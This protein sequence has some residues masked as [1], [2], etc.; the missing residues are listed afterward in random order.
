LINI[1]AGA[2]VVETVEG[3]MVRVLI[4]C[5]ALLLT[6]I[7]IHAEANL[8][9]PPV[10][11]ATQDASFLKYR[12]ALLNAVIA[13]DTEAVVGFSSPKISLSFGGN[14]GHNELRDNLNVPVEKLADQYKPRAPQMRAAY[15]N[16][17]ETTLKMGGRFVEG[18]FYA[19]Y[20]WLAPEPRNMDPYDVYYVVGHNV[21]MRTSGKVDAPILRHLSYHAVEVYLW[22]DDADY[23]SIKLPDGT[24]GY[25]ATKYLRFL[26]DY[27]AIFHQQNGEWMMT[28]FLAGD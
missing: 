14:E 13:R 17:L 7:V 21:R 23:Q 6:P 3:N 22:S 10:D 16:A 27:R 19:P 28:G 12:T 9:V 26:L 5:F 24:Q 11:E 2:T 25:V 20:T 15:W 4:L 1:A 18:G 8:V